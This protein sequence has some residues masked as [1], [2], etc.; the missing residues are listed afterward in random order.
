MFAQLVMQF[1]S[2]ALIQLGYIAN[3]QSNK[4]EK[5]LQQAKY[6]IDMLVMIQEKTKG[7]LSEEESK[8]ISS[9]V[10]NLQMNFINA[11]KEEKEKK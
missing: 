4:V 10:S 8:L 11:G 7:N 2:A 5:N 6:F 3:P 9:T 1:Q